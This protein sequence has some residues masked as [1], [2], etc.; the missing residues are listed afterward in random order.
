LALEAWGVLLAIAFACTATTNW[1]H[2]TVGP[3]R[4]ALWMLPLVFDTFLLPL[5]VASLGPRL[6]AAVIG[7]AVLAL[8]GQ[9]GLVAARGLDPPEDYLEHSYVARFVLG[10][11]PSLYAPSPEIFAERTR[12]T[13]GV[14]DEPVVY[15]VD[16]RCRKVM[17]QKRH[18]SDVL[19]LCGA[20]ARTP[21]FKTLA[22]AS[23][24]GEWVYVD[25]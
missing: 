21:D 3:S 19:A 13:E 16:G 23:R 7:L 6:R 15:R 24:R 22:A 9:A 8:L 1:N 2:G 20:P 17:T 14:P 5:G 10:H 18:W 11:A 12:G 4:Y 25:Y